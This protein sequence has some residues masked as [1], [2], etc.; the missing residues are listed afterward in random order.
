MKAVILA[1]GGGTRLWPLST[2]EKPKQFQKLISEKTMLEE[3]VE[4]IDFLRPE[5]IFIAINEKHLKD[6]EEICPQVPKE[7]ILIEPALRDTASCIGYAAAV[8][9][10][11]HPGEVMVVIY[12]DHLVQNKEEFQKKIRLAAEIAERENTLNIVEVE[13]QNPNTNYGYV[14]IGKELEPDVFELISFTEKPDQE[15][16]EKFLKSGDYLWNTG[17]YV[18]KAKTLLDKFAQ[19]QPETYEKLKTIVDSND[20]ALYPE[21]EKISIDYAIMEK[22]EA[23]EVR[24]IR[25]NDLGWSDIGNWEAIWEELATHEQE[26]ITRGEVINIDSKGSLAYSDNNKPIAIVGLENI[27]VVDTKDGLL[28]CSKEQSKAIKKIQERLH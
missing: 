2:P 1:G 14:K 27:I 20:L 8:I 15:T 23:R 21:L 18:W 12:A 13:A 22:V 7:N 28:V 5:D 6:T 17:I 19:H 4:R 11:R 25:A 9:E 3:T 24:I 10:K 26:N 16:A